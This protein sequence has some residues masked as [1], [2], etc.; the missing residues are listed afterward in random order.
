MVRLI[1]R[2]PSPHWN[3][4]GIENL[5]FFMPSSFSGLPE[6]DDVADLMQ[7][8]WAMTQEIKAVS[9][10]GR[11]I[12]RFEGLPESDDV[13]DLMQ[14]MWA[15]TQEIKAVSKPGRQIGRFE[16][17]YSIQSSHL[18]FHS[19][20]SCIPFLTTNCDPICENQA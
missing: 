5:K 8:M 9:K 13:A 14:Q 16:V 19:F 6:S 10:P 7:Q 4:F 12:G 1:L 3:T 11:Q 17:C 20:I 15:M 2:Q 18:F